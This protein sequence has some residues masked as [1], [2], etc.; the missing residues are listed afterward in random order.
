MGYILLTC[1]GELLAVIEVW[2]TFNLHVE[3]SF[4]Q[5][6]RYGLHSTHL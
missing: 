6:Y 3:V 4:W 2:V 5:G 1:R